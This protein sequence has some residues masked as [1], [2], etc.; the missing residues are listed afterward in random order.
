[1]IYLKNGI[2]TESSVYY[3]GFTLFSQEILSLIMTTQIDT[4]IHAFERRLIPLRKA[5]G[6]GSPVCDLQGNFVL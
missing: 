6:P 2:S 1:M 5:L 4:N 3:G